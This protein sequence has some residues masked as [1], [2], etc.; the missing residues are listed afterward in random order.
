MCNDHSNYL[1]QMRD[2]HNL[3]IYFRK[4][5]ERYRLPLLD[6]LAN[7]EHSEIVRLLEQSAEIV[8]SLIPYI[9]KLPP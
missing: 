8:E 5:S 7:L 3:S 9:E 6:E 4:L 1:D 2:H